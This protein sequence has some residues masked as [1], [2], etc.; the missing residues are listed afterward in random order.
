MGDLFPVLFSPENA[1]NLKIITKEK[2]PV[3]H[4]GILV[5]KVSFY[6]HTFKL[7]SIGSV[8]TAPE[9]RGKGLATRLLLYTE[10]YLRESGIPVMLISG[11]RGLYKRHGC[12]EFGIIYYFDL[13]SVKIEK[14]H[15]IEVKEYD[16]SELNFIL[17]L[18]QQEP[19]RFFR[20]RCH[21]KKILDI[22]CTSQDS[23]WSKFI[24]IKQNNETTAYV[25]LLGRREKNLIKSVKVFEY[26]GDRDHL[27][28]SIPL[29]KERFLKSGW[30]FVWPVPHQD[31]EMVRKMCYKKIPV[32]IRPLN[33][34]TIK[35]IDF[36]K[37]MDSLLEY[38][39]ERIEVE[40]SY[41]KSSTEF[42]IRCRKE[43]KGK[44]AELRFE[45]FGA[46]HFFLFGKGNES[47]QNKNIKYHGE[48]SLLYELS[49]AFPLPTITPGLNYI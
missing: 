45:N 16:P 23:F 2:E 33:E 21:I 8:C 20:K 46:L 36:S 48:Q 31:E 6:G 37:L 10:E 26:A 35:V 49:K 11:T 13:S 29:I 24:V 1:K 25:V 43:G 17:K 19:V 38:I 14:L 41:E 30:K 3:S 12:D 5:N 7:A 22:I 32:K 42:L 15:S 28:S 27:I 4:I 44:V 18:Y 34:H 9:H 39:F 47:R 40:F